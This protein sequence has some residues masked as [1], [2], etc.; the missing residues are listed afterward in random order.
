MHPRSESEVTPCRSPGTLFT[1][2]RT[3]ILLSIATVVLA[4]CGTSREALTAK[5][6]GCATRHVNLVPSQYDRKGMETS[7]CATCKGKLYQCVTNADR[8]R[9]S[10]KESKEGDGCI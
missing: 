6:V 1:I 9:S 8:T 4:G 3:L 7:W 10:C 5:A 2:A